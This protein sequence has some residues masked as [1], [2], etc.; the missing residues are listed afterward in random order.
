MKQASSKGGLESTQTS[1][2]SSPAVVMPQETQSQ[3]M[4]AAGHGA[5]VVEWPTQ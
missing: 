1:T 5:M 4:K 3:L 2:R